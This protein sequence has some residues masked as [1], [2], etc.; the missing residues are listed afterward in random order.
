MNGATRL[1]LACGV[2]AGPAFIT[3]FLIEGAKRADYDALR[4]PVSSLALGER[5]PVQRANFYVTGGLYLA[6]SIGLARARRDAGG[7]GGGL[8]VS[9]LPGRVEP[10]LIAAAAAGLLAAGRFV[11]NPVSGYPPGTPDVP[12]R[13]TTTGALHD[14]AAVPVFLG[15]PAAALASAVG[16]A[17]RGR[18]RWA[19]YSAASGVG[20][21]AAT[22]A[23]SAG[24]AQTPRL[25]AYGGVLQ[26]AAVTSGFAWLTALH[27]R[28]LRA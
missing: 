12:A 24:F 17:R 20:M 4:H 5:G 16:S 13:R 11:T 1:L 23:A 6:G 28:A 9:G 26:R 8:A 2:A 21:L 3:T 27:V 7:D 25:V 19:T 10:P 15:I 14:L 18:W 22:V